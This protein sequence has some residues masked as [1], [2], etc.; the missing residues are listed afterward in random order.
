M[1]G[2]DR[3]REIP[4][5]ARLG[6]ADIAALAARGVER[7]YGP[8]SA[9]VQQ[10]DVDRSLHL[11]VEG[12]ATV[13][14]ATE[15]GDTLNLAQL[16]PGETLGEFALLDGRERSASVFADGSVRTF[17][18]RRE[19]FVDW[20]RERPEAALELLA[21]LSRRLRE[22]D[23]SLT[24]SLFLSVPERL[25]KRLLALGP[26]GRV[27]HTT[28]AELATPLGVTREIVNKTLRRFEAAG[29]VELGRGRVRVVDDEALESVA[30]GSAAR[31]V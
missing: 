26:A 14:I 28:Q 17:Q 1:A 5:L 7:N 21:T 16:G 9:I 10:G 6:K 19:D 22:T 18:I 27:I 8:G 20:L 3:L 30:E 11:I 13:S 24:D 23:A 25:A 15:S 2:E 31:A 4:F 29:T 12:R